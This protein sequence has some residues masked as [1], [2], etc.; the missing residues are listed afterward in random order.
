[1]SDIQFGAPTDPAY[2]KFYKRFEQVVEQRKDWRW[3]G[4][5]QEWYTYDR[6]EWIMEDAGLADTRPET[7][8]TQDYDTFPHLDGR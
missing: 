2:E 7:A 6:A 1:M 4:R 8:M 5:D 3:H